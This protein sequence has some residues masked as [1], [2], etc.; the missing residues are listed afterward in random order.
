MF[1]LTALDLARIQFGFTISFHI[2]FPAITIGLASYLAVLEGLWLWK[3]DA[4]YLELYLFWSQIFAVDFR[5]GRRLRPGDGLPVRHQLERLFC[6]R[7]RH[8]RAT[9][10]LRG[11]DRLLPGGRLP[12]CD[13]VRLEQGRTG[14]A[15]LRYGDGRG[16]HADLGDMD[17][18]LQQVDADAAGLRDRR[19]PRRAHRLAEGDLQ[20]LVSLSSR[21]YDGG[22]LSGHRAVRGRVGAWHLLKRRDT[23][24]VRTM[25]S[26]A[27]WMV[28]DRRAGAD[29]GRRRAR[30][31]HAEHQPAKIAAIEG[32]W[33]N[34]PGA[35]VPLILFGWPDMAAETTRYA[36]EVPISAA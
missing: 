13:A 14:P 9:A 26:M 24:A 11:A 30:S 27:M 29:R 7:R 1:G 32:H 31:Q 23:P 12:W 6:L 17:P 5:D 25:L 21:P 4:V 2:V 28:A 15:L 3:K 19:R 35:S 20:P 18:R 33:E 34:Q 22:G 8:H 10:Q 36:V 16:R